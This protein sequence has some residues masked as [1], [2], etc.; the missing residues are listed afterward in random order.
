MKVSEPFKV[1]GERPSEYFARALRA[2][3]QDLANLFPQQLEIECRGESF[4]VRVQCDRKRLESKKPQARKKGLGAFIGRVANYRLDKPTE[5]SDVVTHARTYNPDDINR[6]DQS[7][8]DRR[9]QAGKV[10]DIYSLGETLRTIG[11]IVDSN[12]GR[13]V[14]IFKDQRRVAVEY[15]DK[16][17]SKCREE[18]TSSEL[19]KLQQRYYQER[20]GSTNPDFFTRH[21]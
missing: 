18:M 8:V 19:Y 15:T 21:D 7:G 12:G 6:L 13:L 16:K 9:T 5:E 4:E 1:K 17:G 20:S 3:G 11:R 14:S 10:P 2:I